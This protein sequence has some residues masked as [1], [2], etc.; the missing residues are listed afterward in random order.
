MT[1][2]NEKDDQT[3][4]HVAFDDEPAE[5]FDHRTG[6]SLSLT[7]VQQDESGRRYVEAEAEQGRYQDERRKRAELEGLLDEQRGQKDAN[8]KR[9]GEREQQVQQLRW[10]WQD[11]HQ[12]DAD[13]SHRDDRVPMAP[14]A[15]VARVAREG[16][17]GGHAR[18]YAR[19]VPRLRPRSRYTKASTRATAVKWATGT[20]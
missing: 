15:R 7:A 20:G 2:E 6:G 14:F 10:Q 17:L 19:R 16:G 12:H 4:E 13:D 18:S 5:R 9:H 8:R 3:D 11:H 1:V